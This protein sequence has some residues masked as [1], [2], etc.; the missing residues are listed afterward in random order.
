MVHLHFKDLVGVTTRRDVKELWE[1]RKELGVAILA[2][3]RI[4]GAKVISQI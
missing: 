2:R 4:Y 3:K 1:S